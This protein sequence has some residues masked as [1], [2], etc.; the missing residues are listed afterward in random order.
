M[1]N[2]IEDNIKQIEIFEL[3][4][5]EMHS[6][7]R[8]VKASEYTPVE[9]YER[10]KNN[11]EKVFHNRIVF[12]NISPSKLISTVRIWNIL[13]GLVLLL[14]LCV[15]VILVPKILT[16]F[17]IAVIVLIIVL[18]SNTV[19]KQGRKSL[20]EYLEVCDKNRPHLEIRKMRDGKISIVAYQRRDE[21]PARCKAPN[22]DEM[23]ES[24]IK[25][26][27]TID[28]IIACSHVKDGILIESKGI[29]HGLRRSD[30]WYTKNGK[31]AF[32]YNGSYQWVELSI[33]YRREVIPAIF[34]DMDE[35]ETTLNN[36]DAN[37]LKEEL[38]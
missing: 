20:G 19:R 23:I 37:E 24:V 12:E 17:I 1:S 27:Y 3:Q 32:E 18:L 14:G 38:K 30:E 9:Y 33:D 4:R 34:E 36:Y 29:F 35:L 7:E 13:G 11:T 2:N 16:K 28:K 26:C 8:L 25:Y 31:E 21:K 10:L 5:C 15:T 22:D 6:G